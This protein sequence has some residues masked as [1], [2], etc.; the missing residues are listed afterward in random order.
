MNGL[1]R[2][3]VLAIWLLCLLFNGAFTAV[4]EDDKDANDPSTSKVE[5]ICHPGKECYPKT[6]V[7]TTTFMPV[8]TD[9]VIPPGLHVR[10]NIG[11]GGRE[12]KLI[13]PADEEGTAVYISADKPA[14]T[15]IIHQYSE[16]AVVP[17]AMEEA[18]VMNG[19]RG[20]ET[21]NGSDEPIVF[22]PSG[23]HS[24][25]DWE[26]FHA[27]VKVLQDATP[28]SAGLDSAL[29]RL[30]DMSHELEYGLKLIETS[31]RRL[32]HIMTSQ[33]HETP[34]RR[35]AAVAFGNS[36]QNN[37]AALSHVKEQLG[38]DT[39]E[40]LFKPL[41]DAIVDETDRF[42]VRRLMFA[43]SRA[44]RVHHGKRDFI[45][46]DGLPVLEIVFIRTDDMALRG[47]IA[48]FLFDEFL[49]PNMMEPETASGS[50]GGS[51]SQ[52]VI[53]FKDDLSGWCEVFQKDLM[54]RKSNAHDNEHRVLE[55]LKA[56]KQKYGEGCKARDDLKGW[57]AAEIER[58]DEDSSLK[59][60]LEVPLQDVQNAFFG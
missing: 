28:G 27:A 41:L 7:P 10:L 21:N 34:H 40:V 54:G 20:N 25:P 51:G 50:T 24:L 5:M 23:R 8:E 14:G 53:Q 49:D 42:L 22:R 43:L 48:T 33:S 44:V 16:L 3:A 45:S 37:A 60:W 30:A 26:T 32:I 47:K 29:D 57:L 6:F 59:D 52:K 13:D 9:Q 11:S 35:V 17:D 55:T 4:V 36:L 19:G 31:L 46:L 1:N 38:A 58:V 2:I 12:A 18:A 15:P 56:L 39:K